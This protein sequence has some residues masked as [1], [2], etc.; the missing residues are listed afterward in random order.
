MRIYKDVD[1]KDFD[2]WGGAKGTVK[3]LTDTEGQQVFDWLEADGQ[4]QPLSETEVNDFFWFETDT[5]ADLLGYE[6]W[7]ALMDDRE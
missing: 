5:I 3:Y 4:W 6:D 7:N 2:F 1:Y